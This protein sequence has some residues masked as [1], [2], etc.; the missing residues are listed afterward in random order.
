V[1]R[2]LVPL[3]SGALFGAG[4]ILSGMTQPAKV[5]G[6]LDVTGAWDPSLA[7]VMAGA[8]AVHFAAYRL[9]PHMPSPLFAGAF[10]LP[11]RRDLDAQLL[12]GAALFGI[13]WGLSGFCPGPALASL[14]SGTAPVLV[15]V[16]AMLGGMALFQ[17]LDRAA[18]NAHRAAPQR[19][20]RSLWLLWPLLLAVPPA[21]AARPE[22]PTPA[23]PEE[24]EETGLVFALTTGPE[25]LGTLSSAF[26]HAKTARDS[27][28]IEQVTV[29]VYGRAIVVFDPDVALPAEVRSLVSE[30]RAA[31]VR[32]VA[33]ETA[34]A[35]HGISPQAAAESAELVPQG[36]VEVARLVARGHEVLTY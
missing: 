9:V 26:R 17:R 15:F 13:G 34:L 27:G 12:G 24:R 28:V 7:L 20:L 19:I 29:I 31:G 6:F 3:L 4:L 2:W 11:G 14:P 21:E 8:I 36:I 22:K 30:A 25:D 18:H 16:A 33:C 35:K 23:G 5:I 1:N 32:I 10:A